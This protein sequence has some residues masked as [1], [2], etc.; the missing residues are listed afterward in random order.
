MGS[1]SNRSLSE[2]D[3]T[4]RGLKMDLPGYLLGQGKKALK[5]WP[6]L[7]RS[8]KRTA[9]LRGRVHRA[10][11]SAAN[12]HIACDASLSPRGAS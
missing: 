11:S 4:G 8:L 6:E 2:P 3:P 10:V 12:G 7:R 5:G 1:G 9:L